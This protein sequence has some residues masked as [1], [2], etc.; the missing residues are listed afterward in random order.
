MEFLTSTLV[1]GVI[2]LSFWFAYK[3]TVK[4]PFDAC[5]FVIY[6]LALL[7]LLRPFLLLFRIDGPM[8]DFLWR[9]DYITVVWVTS[10]LGVGWMFSF[11]VG[12]R[13]SQGLAPKLAVVFPPMPEHPRPTAVLLVLII[14]TGISVFG[15]LLLWTKTGG[16]LQESLSGA[17]T[18][19]VTKGFALFTQMFETGMY[20]AVA[21]TL[22]SIYLK[23]NFG[24]RLPR[25]MQLSFVALLGV[26][27]TSMLYFGERGGLVF[28]AASLVLGY[29][30]T[31]RHWSFWKVSLLV[32]V[33]IIFAI[34]LRAGRDLLLFGT[35]RDAEYHSGVARLVSVG[36]NL[37][38]FDYFMLVVR[39]WGKLYEFRIG[40]DFLVGFVGV[41]PRSLWA[42]KPEVIHFGTWLKDYY[43]GERFG[44]W[45]VTTIGQ[46]YANFSYAGIILGGAVAGTLYR[47]LQWR[48]VKAAENPWAF[49]FM[50]AIVFDVLPGGWNAVTPIY[51]ILYATPLYVI[52]LI[53]RR[54]NARMSGGTYALSPG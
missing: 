21:T 4:H 47:A 3:S 18:D 35:L 6:I 24:I 48:Y 46:W 42:G 27:I 49:I 5:A 8:P 15:L 30:A 33:P 45:P 7:F 38:M 16:G 39:D 32:V 54:T 31:L 11:S 1:F 53:L 44:G 50:F 25:L 14:V 26:N 40:E 36:L 10:L 12:Y 43:L 34:G 22:Y 13:F 2:L 28:A 52:G 29:A 17:R 23:R 19:R 37:N 9:E 20:V 41:I 51:L